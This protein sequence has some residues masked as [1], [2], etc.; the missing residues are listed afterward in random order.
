MT[1]A[2]MSGGSPQFHF[3]LNCFHLVLMEA[4]LT[5]YGHFGTRFRLVTHSMASAERRRLQSG[6]VTTGILAGMCR[7]NRNLVLNCNQSR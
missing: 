3:I 4:M 1:A 5:A 2:T 7:P 6:A